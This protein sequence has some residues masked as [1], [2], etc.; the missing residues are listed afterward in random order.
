MP[1]ASRGLS[2]VPVSC[3]FH[4][5]Y[6]QCLILLQKDIKPIYHTIWVCLCIL[7]DLRYNQGAV[8]MVGGSVEGEVQMTHEKV[9][10]E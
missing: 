6:F 2:P 1:S 4:A 10:R 7:R 8:V 9:A 3:G 5:M